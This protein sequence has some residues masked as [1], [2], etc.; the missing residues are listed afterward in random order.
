MIDIVCGKKAVQDV[1]SE[2]E[3]LC[4]EGLMVVVI[5]LAVVM[6]GQMGTDSEEMVRSCPS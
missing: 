1:L 5:I 2:D 4:E 6:D 3:I